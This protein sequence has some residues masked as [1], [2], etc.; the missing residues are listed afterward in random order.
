VSGENGVWNA[1]CVVKPD[2]DTLLAWGSNGVWIVAG[3]RPT[4]ISG[5]IDDDWR[6]IINYSQT[7]LIHGWYAPETGEVKW[8]FAEGSSSLLTRVL[9]YD[10]AGRRWRID[11]YRIGLDGSTVVDDANGRIRSCVSDATNDMTYYEG[12]KTDGVPTTLAGQGKL[13]VGTGGTT[14]TTPVAESL[15]TGAKGASLAGLSLYAPTLGETVIIASNT[16]DTITHAAFSAALTNGLE[17]F[18]GSIPVDVSIGWWAGQDQSIEKVP[19]KVLLY[20]IPS[21]A[22]TVANVF[23]Y[24]DFS[25]SPFSRPA[26]AGR[27]YPKGVSRLASGTG[28]AVDLSVSD[29]YI[30]IPVGATAAK[31]F[32]VRITCDDPSGEFTILDVQWKSGDRAQGGDGE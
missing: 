16:A 1:R 5:P 12:G 22:A 3:G 32:R 23:L 2:S 14:T 11:K 9:V 29:G 13:T 8:A 27:T 19:E 24:R 25:A 21:S 28:L 6:A 18:V 30:E 7:S 31:V 17:C 15:P 26:M 10:M 20:A 4:Q